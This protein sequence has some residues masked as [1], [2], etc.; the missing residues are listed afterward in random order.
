[1]AVTDALRETHRVTRSRA[2]IQRQHAYSEDGGLPPLCDAGHV[3]IVVA[4][5][6]PAPSGMSVTMHNLLSRF[7]PASYSVVTAGGLTHRAIEAA[8]RARVY[9]V[10]STLRR[11]SSRLDLW[12]Q[13]RKLKT[14]ISLLAELV[15]RTGA[16]AMVGVYPTFH[17]LKLAREAARATG[18]PWVAYLHDTVAEGLANSALAKE[19]VC[20]Q[21]QVFAEA[22]SVLVMSGGMAEL[23]TRKYGLACAALE[24]TYPEPIPDQLPE[25]TALRQAF[26]AG[27]T[28]GINHKAVARV[29][30]ALKRLDCPLLMTT[31]AK[32]RSLMQQGIAGD[33]VKTTFF[34]KREDYL[35]ALQ[36]QGVLILA[37]NWP[38]EGSLHEDELATIFPTKTP[39]YLASG[40]PILVHCPDHYFLARYFRRH[41]CGLIVSERSEAGLAE[42][43]GVLLTDAPE[44]RTMRQAG[45]I[46][47]QQFSAEAIASRLRGAVKAAVQEGNH[48]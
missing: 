35:S 20:L 23:Y 45:L 42:A 39:E 29:S 21:N 36:R 22:A 14:T 28:Y 8:E 27:A 3:L 18:T 6:P 34:P 2:P 40:R 12:W 11:V 46:A 19:A 24:H 38:D 4:Y 25:H 15:A 47:A 17:F 5:Y 44:V 30:A 26:W 48:A 1:M 32:P 13:D 37:L 41:G 43:I 10:V 33:H 31:T 9:R 7:H 16:K